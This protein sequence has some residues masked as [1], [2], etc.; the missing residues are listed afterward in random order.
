M[1]QAA[2]CLESVHRT[3]GGGTTRRQVAPVGGDSMRFAGRGLLTIFAVVL[4]VGCGSDAPACGNGR[5]E[6]AEVCESSQAGCSS[7][8]RA[9]CG[10]HIFGPGEV[11]ET[12]QTGCSSDCRSLCGDGF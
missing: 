1:H 4:V 7:D 12:W 9:L 2:R 11:C 10:D 6:G 5:L 8:C 3:G